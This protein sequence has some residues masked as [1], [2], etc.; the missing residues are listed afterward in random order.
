MNIN[1]AVNISVAKQQWQNLYKT[2]L[3]A[4][5]TIELI[6]PATNLPDMVFTAN[7][8]LINRKTVCLSHF[9]LLERQGESSYFSFWFEQ[10]GLEVIKIEPYFEGAG[11]ALFLGSKLI[12]AY[13]FRSQIEAYQQEFFTQFELVFCELVNPYF[14]HLDTCFCPLS[15]NLAMCYSG[16]FNKETK[17]NL[18]KNCELI[19]VT[20]EEANKFACNSI[21][22]GKKI[23]IPAGCHK[24][25]KTLESLGFIVYSCD[26]SEYIKAGGACKC[27]TLE[28]D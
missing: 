16:A 21:V 1:N 27:L 25:T 14:Y 13:G 5:A 10:Q 6:D 2:I 20:E 12:V 3:K 4:G 28:L 9:K 19:L 11:D 7:A 17:K 22:I 24:V 8:G 26:M 23:I 18:E 15:A